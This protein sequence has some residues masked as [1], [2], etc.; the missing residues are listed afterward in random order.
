MAQLLGIRGD[1][2]ALM[3]RSPSCPRA[4]DHVVDVV[5]HRARF[6]FHRVVDDG[7]K[8]TGIRRDHFTA[9]VIPEIPFCAQLRG[10]EFL[11]SAVFVF[12]RF[13]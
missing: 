4:S 11:G 9:W 10:L 7:L 3:A 2:E 13:F 12:A 5:G 6:V 1:R 8:L